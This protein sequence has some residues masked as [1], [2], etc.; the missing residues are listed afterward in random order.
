MIHVFDALLVGI[1]RKL[2]SAT[3]TGL[4]FITDVVMASGYPVKILLLQGVMFSLFSLL[5]ILLCSFLVHT[6]RI[7]Q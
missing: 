6:Q 4:D 1:R 3:G 5:S 2:F 7:C